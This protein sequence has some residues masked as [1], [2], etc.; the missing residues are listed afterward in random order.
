MDWLLVAVILVFGAICGAV[1]RLPIFII[2]LIAASVIVLF[3]NWPHGA[4]AALL[5]AVIAVVV[6]QCGYAAGILSRSLMRSLRGGR[7]ASDKVVQRR[8]VPLP[9][10]PKQP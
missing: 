7:P 2:A 6:L 3:A 8:A 4:G 9:N 10:E 5:Q 1:M